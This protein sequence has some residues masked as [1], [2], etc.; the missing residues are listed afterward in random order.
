MQARVGRPPG[1]WI[2]AF[3]R[4][5]E[6]ARGFA[7]LSPTLLIML[8][9]LAAPMGLLAV[10]SFWSQDGLVLD[11]HFTLDQ[12]KTAFGRETYRELFYRS[13]SGSRNRNSSG[14]FC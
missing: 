4:R 12:Y 9:A 11:T 1:I 7:L 3:F 10:Y 13:P 8:V 5:S 6:S 2:G 14:L